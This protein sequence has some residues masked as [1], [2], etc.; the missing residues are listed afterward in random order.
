[1]HGREGTDAA[2]RF[3]QNG[4]IG[5]QAGKFQSCHGYRGLWGGLKPSQLYFVAT[6]HLELY[7]MTFSNFGNKI[8]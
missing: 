8:H 2:L 5:R 3:R 6:I 4:S 1:L 7:K